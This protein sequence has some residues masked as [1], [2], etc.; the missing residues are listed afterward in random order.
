MFERGALL[1]ERFRVLGSIDAERGLIEADDL[2]GRRVLLVARPC[3][4]SAAEVA[5][6]GESAARFGLGCPGLGRPLSATSVDGQMLV[7]FRMPVRASVALEREPWAAARVLSLVSRVARAVGPLHEQGIGHGS[8][9]AEFVFEH[10]ADVLLGFTVAALTRS[11]EG[12]PAPEPASD[13][14]DLQRLAA[15]LL[16][17][18]RVT[19][20]MPPPTPS[21]LGAPVPAALDAAWTRSVD[22]EAFVADL[23]RAIEVKPQ[24]EPRTSAAPE[25]AALDGP[26]LPLPALDALSSA[27]VAPTSPRGPSP[28]PAPRV[29]PRAPAFSKSTGVGAVVALLLGL[30]MMLGGAAG[31]FAYVIHKAR[32]TSAPSATKATTSPL[33]PAPSALMPPKEETSAAP[34]SDEEPPPLAR[35]RPHLPLVAAGVGQGTSAQDAR[36]VLPVQST[37]AIWGTRAATVTLVLFGDLQCPYTRRTLRSLEK[38]KAAFGDDLRLVFRHRPLADHPYALTAA[39][40]LAGVRARHGSGAF[41]RILLELISGEAPITAESLLSELSATEIAEPLDTLESLGVSA[42]DADLTLAAQFGIRSTPYA[43]INGSRVDG[44]FSYQ[45]LE[46]LLGDERRAAVWSLAAGTSAAELYSVRSSVNLIGVGGAV[47]NRN[48][49]PLAGSPW[50]GAQGAPVTLVEFADFECPYCKRVE[51][52]LSTLLERHPGKLRVVWKNFPLPQHTQAH[53]LST[54]A[55][56]ALSAGGEQGFWAVHDA[57]MR[58]KTELDD[59]ALVALG[60]RVGLDGSRLLASASSAG[61]DASVRADLA[62]AERLNVTGTPTFFING[63]RLSGALPLA[64]FEQ[65][66]AQELKTADHFVA[67]GTAPD[68]VYDRVCEGSSTTDAG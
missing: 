52:T 37:D 43:F 30:L 42:V 44:D 31:A 1:A 58:S 47:A 51:D 67:S 23:T 15:E 45:K 28:K 38:L 25:G 24:V 4:L 49:V 53:L 36:A 50:R 26:A 18:R 39:R 14:R 19:E 22:V 8:I 54:F 68:K 48:C 21:A 59:A 34:L 65:V 35:S 16:A 17:G 55:A 9:T 61:H 41:Y 20:E 10:D 2:A 12:K 7:A 29:P 6:R 32:V 27:P 46:S 63:R 62:L 40:V 11:G 66:L 60:E 5:Q 56:E 3:P 13:V 64:D 57:L 33:P